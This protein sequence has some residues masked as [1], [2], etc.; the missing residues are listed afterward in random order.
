METPGAVLSA[1]DSTAARL[2]AFTPT[3]AC[4]TGGRGRVAVPSSWPPP[5][6]IPPSPPSPSSCHLPRVAVEGWNLR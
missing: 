2:S 4:V 5:C 3:P 1:L 6:C